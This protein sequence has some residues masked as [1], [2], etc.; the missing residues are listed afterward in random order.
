MPHLMDKLPAALAD[1]LRSR[2]G[3]QFVRFVGVAL[4]SL[5]TSEVVLFV[6]IGLNFGG[7]KSGFAAAAAGA[8]VSYALSRRAWERTGRPDLLRETIPFW[9]VSIAVWFVLALATKLGIHLA[10]AQ[11]AQGFERR[12]II[13]TVYFVANCVT[14]MTRFLIFHYIL[15]A[16]SS[17]GSRGP[18]A[19]AAGP[20]EAETITPVRV[21]SRPA[22]NDDD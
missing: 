11:G 1:R 2:V 12:A 16:D 17:K 5:F 8:G 18:G 22:D 9:A 3:R 6:L 7:Y 20:S 4:A 10:D 14:F 19:G 15:F 13:G 21:P